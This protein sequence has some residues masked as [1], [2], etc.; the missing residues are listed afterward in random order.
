MQYRVLTGY[1]YAEV[2][3]FSVFVSMIVDRTF[4]LSK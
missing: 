1:L 2:P 4:L 3:A